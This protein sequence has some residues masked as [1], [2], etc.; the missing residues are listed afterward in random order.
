[1]TALILFVVVIGLLVVFDLLAIT[2]GVD[3]RDR[4]GD[5]HSRPVGG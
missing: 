1:M 3:S 4:L 5:D 2:R